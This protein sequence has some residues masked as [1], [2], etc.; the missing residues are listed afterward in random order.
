MKGKAKDYKQFSVYLP[1]KVYERL[2]KEADKKTVPMAVLVRQK[3]M[4]V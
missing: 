1:L 2:K 4:G 3:I